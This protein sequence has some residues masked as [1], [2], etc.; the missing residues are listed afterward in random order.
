MAAFQERQR[1]AR[2]Q[3]LGDEV[4][5]ESPSRLD[6]LRAALRE[7]LREERLVGVVAA[8][9]RHNWRASA[10][11]LSR[12]HPTRWGERGGDMPLTLDDEADPFTEFDQLGES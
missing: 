3:L 1:E 2:V 7:A 4:A 9:A 5:D 6:Q 10:W 8:E 11:L 12:M